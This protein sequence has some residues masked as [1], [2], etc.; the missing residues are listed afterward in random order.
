MQTDGHP[1]AAPPSLL[2]PLGVRRVSRGLSSQAQG[3]GEP[4]GFWDKFCTVGLQGALTAALYKL[5]PDSRK[6]EVDRAQAPLSFKFTL[7]SRMPQIFPLI[8]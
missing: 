3:T 6:R 4:G 8:F 7:I 5:Q 1:A 2:W